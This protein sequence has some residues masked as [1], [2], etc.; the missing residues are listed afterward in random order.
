MSAVRDALA[1]DPAEWRAELESAGEF[2]EKIGPTI[3]DELKERRQA[4]L[5]S[6]NGRASVQ[7]VAADR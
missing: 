5:K 2:F 4:I 7:Q 3:P 6:L 1:V